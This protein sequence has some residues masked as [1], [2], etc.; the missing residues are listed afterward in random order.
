MAGNGDGG[1]G[2][3][4]PVARART[5]HAPIT[6]R[7]DIL[8]A[9]RR[10]SRDMLSTPLMKSAK[11]TSS[12]T[13]GNN[14]L[15]RPFSPAPCARLLDRVAAAGHQGPKKGRT[16]LGLPTTATAPFCPSEVRGT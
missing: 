11:Q 9:P 4:P 7:R 10:H 12:L 6:H 8:T 13:S 3:H 14:G 1:G 2:V 15:S 16:M 5:T